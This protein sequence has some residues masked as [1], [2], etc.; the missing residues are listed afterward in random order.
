MWK[1]KN[2]ELRKVYAKSIVHKTGFT[3]CANDVRH[4]L[5]IV[6]DAKEFYYWSGEFGGWQTISN[7]F[8]GCG[9]LEKALVKRT[10]WMVLDAWFRHKCRLMV[11]I[12]Q[13]I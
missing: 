13:N 7:I 9:N 5:K 8:Y 3:D 6:L 4:L 12:M 10:C 2:N 11:F 1:W